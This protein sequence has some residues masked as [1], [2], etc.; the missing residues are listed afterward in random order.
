MKDL[1]PHGQS[2]Q[3]AFDVSD[4]NA[5][6]LPNLACTVVCHT[7]TSA[8][9]APEAAHSGQSSQLAFDEITEW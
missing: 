5:Q 8:S 7:G 2:S 4:G 3:L 1:S 6:F 9:K